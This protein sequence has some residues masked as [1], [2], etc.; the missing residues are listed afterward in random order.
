MKEYLKLKELL[1]LI[2]MLEK[3]KVKLDELKLNEFSTIT[4]LNMK[5]MSQGKELVRIVK[6]SGVSHNRVFYCELNQAFRLPFHFQTTV[7]PL[8]DS[9]AVHHINYFRMSAIPPH[10]LYTIKSSLYNS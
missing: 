1:V 4:E 7:L 3:K 6:D 5:L 2:V 10:K 9:K 8:E